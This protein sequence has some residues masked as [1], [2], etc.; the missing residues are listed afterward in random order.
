[1]PQVIEFQSCLVGSR[2][3]QIDYESVPFTCFH[4][5]KASHK[6]GLCPLFKGKGK[7]G[8]AKNQVGKKSTNAPRKEWKKKEIQDKKVGETKG[9][10]NNIIVPDPQP[11]S[12]VHQK[13][14][15]AVEGAMKVATE[16]KTNP[17]HK[18]ET[19][20]NHEEARKEEI[21][22]LVRPR[23]VDPDLSCVLDSQEILKEGD[24]LSQDS[25]TSP[26]S[27]EPPLSVNRILE[28]LSASTPGQLA[29]IDALFDKCKE[30]EYSP[31]SEVRRRTVVIPL[32]HLLLQPGAG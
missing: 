27:R 22:I 15:V 25:N 13:V 28:Q 16:D 9:K 24:P 6:A 17:S 31:W 26:I 4:C 19:N 14:E 30:D 8:K 21:Q 3:Q 1:M 23:E 20:V 2:I 11:E 12:L 32:R 10:V 7:E 18:K 29:K 5:K